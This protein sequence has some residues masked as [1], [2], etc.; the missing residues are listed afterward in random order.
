MNVRPTRV[1]SNYNSFPV[2]EIKNTAVRPNTV[3]VNRPADRLLQRNKTE[4][5]SCL[6]KKIKRN[7]NFVSYHRETVDKKSIAK[8][9]Y[10]VAGT[11]LMLRSNSYHGQDRPVRTNVGISEM[12]NVRD[13][14]RENR[15]I[16]RKTLAA[17]K[18]VEKPSREEYFKSKLNKTFSYTGFPWHLDEK[19]DWLKL[20]FNSWQDK[21]SALM[22]NSNH[23]DKRQADGDRLARQLQSAEEN[24]Q[25]S[26]NIRFL[27][28][29]KRSRSEMRK[30]DPDYR[31]QKYY[32]DLPLLVET[33]PS[34]EEKVLS[35]L[36]KNVTLSKTSKYD[37]RNAWS[38]K[39]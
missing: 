25:S 29:N 30:T 34:R 4:P 39:I 38:N 13:K 20:T 12:Q 33:D 31:T 37:L 3:K 2:R 26:S 14:S 18:P 24:K 27:L 11:S 15:G 8:K 17:N 35:W 22:I 1:K 32:R 10:L 21:G 7:A 28:E 19:D 16:R 5:P 23:F 36:E 9:K 6:V